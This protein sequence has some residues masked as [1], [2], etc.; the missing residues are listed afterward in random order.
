M[1]F[2][3]HTRLSQMVAVEEFLINLAAN[4]ITYRL[5]G[6]NPP[7]SPERA[8]ARDGGQVQP[9]QRTAQPSDVSHLAAE[10]FLTG[11]LWPLP[12]RAYR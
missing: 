8:Q 11:P 12:R 9:A 10:C 5:T 6:P 3:A 1:S 2:I 4:C 7:A